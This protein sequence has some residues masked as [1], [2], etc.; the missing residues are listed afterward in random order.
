MFTQLKKATTLGAMTLAMLGTT[1]AFADDGPFRPEDFWTTSMAAKMDT[2]KDGMVSRQ[3][4][5]NYMGTQYDKMDTRRKGMLSRVDFS[6][7]Q[8]ASQTFSGVVLE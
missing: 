6:N 3:E 4:F 7:R 2:N 1:P 8:M 5:L